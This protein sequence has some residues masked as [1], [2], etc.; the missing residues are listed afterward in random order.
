MGLVRNQD[1][2]VTGEVEVGQIDDKFLQ[3]IECVCGH[4][5]DPDKWDNI[6]IYPEY[7]EPCKKC[8]RK[9]YF[10]CNIQIYEVVE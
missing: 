4:R 5:Y 10:S 3:I 2:E 6:S 8:S 9:L 7:A 1:K